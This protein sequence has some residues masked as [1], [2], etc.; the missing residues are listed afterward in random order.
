MGCFWKPQTKHN[1]LLKYQWDSNFQQGI[2]F[3][4]LVLKN[5]RS[6]KS[7][8]LSW[9]IQR[10]ITPQVGW[11]KAAMLWIRGKV[12]D[13]RET[14]T[15]D[16]KFGLRKRNVPDIEVRYSKMILREMDTKWPRDRVMCYRYGEV[17][18]IESRLYYFHFLMWKSF[19][20]V[21][22]IMFFHFLFFISLESGEAIPGSFWIAVSSCEETPNSIPCT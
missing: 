15:M 8:V 13:K 4:F 19:Y 9:V 17:R 7:R 18:D 20:R 10:K 12:R 22:I 16:P 21:G 1:V 3:E 11:I 14:Q 2:T 5:T 6:E